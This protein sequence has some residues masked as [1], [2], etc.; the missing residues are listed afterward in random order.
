MNGSK[1]IFVETRLALDQVKKSL[2]EFEAIKKQK[3][4]QDLFKKSRECLAHFEIFTS[5]LYRLRSLQLKD[6]NYLMLEDQASL[7][8]QRII[9]LQRTEKDPY[10]YKNFLSRYRKIWK[11]STALL[12]LMTSLFVVSSVVSFLLVYESPDYAGLLIPAQ[13]IEK[14]ILGKSW[15]SDL[16]I[17]SGYQIA[18][19]NIMVCITAFFLS[20]FLGFGAL[21]ILLF[22]GVHFGAI[23]GFC[24][25][26]GFH[27]QLGNF[28]LSHGPLELSIIIASATSGMLLGK[29]F[30]ERPLFKNFGEKIRKSGSASFTLLSGIIFWLVLAAG[31][32]AF[33]SPSIWIPLKIKMFIG[34]S[35]GTIFWYWN[36]G[37]DPIKEPKNS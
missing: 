8:S 24:Y 17:M 29:A 37:P 31:I 14:I 6:R 10:A 2:D 11:Q 33:I 1:Q 23:M 25:V 20:A 32:E 27:D 9:T 7:I 5:F 13:I 16:S 4:N 19:N 36:F 28:V 30:Y 34:I 15:F 22:N 35:L 26:H 21:Y 3:S 18:L 12:L